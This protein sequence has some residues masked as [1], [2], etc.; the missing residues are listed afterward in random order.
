MEVVDLFGKASEA[1]A[2]NPSVV[3]VF[4]Q[5]GAHV[6]STS[7][8]KNKSSLSLIFLTFQ[9]LK[10]FKI[11]QVSRGSKFYVST[12]YTTLFYSLLFIFYLLEDYSRYFAQRLMELINMYLFSPCVK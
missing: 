11:Q 4:P 3:V 8:G 1:V 5:F 6:V 12:P 10:R 7:G 2:S 9:I